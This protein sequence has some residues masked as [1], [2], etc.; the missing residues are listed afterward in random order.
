MKSKINEQDVSS[1]PQIVLQEGSPDALLLNPKYLKI[2]SLLVNSSTKF[3]QAGGASGGGDNGGGDPVTDRP[4]LDDI[5]GWKYERKA[6]PGGATVVTL[7]IKFR[8]SSGKVIK[9]FD[10]K[11]PQI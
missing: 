10:A 5:I 11:V 7:K 6:A 1:A 8:N 2:E 3:V 4:S 9:G